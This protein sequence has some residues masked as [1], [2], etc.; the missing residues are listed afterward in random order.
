MDKVLRFAGGFLLGAAIGAGAVV[1]L[2]PHSG[3]DTQDMIRL[4][5][6][7][8]LDEGRVA[9]EERRQELTA[10]LEALKEPLP[11]A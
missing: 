2:A 1:L 10:Q 7:N 8:I 9:A 11:R 6:Q 4:R 5:V 3:A